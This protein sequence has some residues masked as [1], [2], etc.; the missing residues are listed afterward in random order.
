MARK[1]SRNVFS[2]NPVVFMQDLQQAIQDGFRVNDTN[3]GYPMLNSI[4]KEVRVY[5]SEDRA[6]ESYV[7][8]SE[9]ITSQHI[10]EWDGMR[11]LLAF[12]N[13]VQQGF[14]VDASSVSFS[15]M[16]TAK[17]V[18]VSTVE[19]D[20]V[21]QVD[22]QADTFVQGQAETINPTQEASPVQFSTEATFQEE[23]DMAAPEKPEPT[24]VV[25]ELAQEGTATTPL[26][27]EPNVDN[28]NRV[29]DQRLPEDQL[30]VKEEDEPKK[31]R[32]KSTKKGE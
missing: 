14:E 30:V 4:L 15:G 25:E 13:L 32:R 28:D 17:L 8:V 22:A 20:E 5:R 21:D 7:P 10:A 1:E 27:P 11:Y 3:E 16:K 18:R 19:V 2:E 12:Q 26:N 31:A 6:P 9:D 24:S 23:E 29:E